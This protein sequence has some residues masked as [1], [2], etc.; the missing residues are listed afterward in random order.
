MYCITFLTWNQ[1]AWQNFFIKLGNYIKWNLENNIREKEFTKNKSNWINY[2][3]KISNFYIE[4][5]ILVYWNVSEY[6]IVLAM[7]IFYFKFAIIFWTFPDIPYRKFKVFLYY[8]NNI[9]VLKFGGMNAN[10]CQL[11]GIP[12]FI[13]L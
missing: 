5:I 1:N 3:Y 12:I 11:E 8:E 4:I 13:W 7:L 10:E 9:D 2:R 6:F